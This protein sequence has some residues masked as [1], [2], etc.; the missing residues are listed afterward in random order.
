MLCYCG[1][2][3]TSGQRKFD[4][5]TAGPKPITLERI[6]SVAEAIKMIKT[7]VYIPT[8]S[9]PL[10]GDACLNTFERGLIYY[11]DQEYSSTGA[12]MIFEWSGPVLET[13][14]LPYPVNT[15][16][17]HPG[18]RAA[19]PVGTNQFLRAVGLIKVERSSWEQMFP[20]PN[21]L[22]LPYCKK[23]WLQARAIRVRLELRQL[24][25]SK[26]QIQVGRF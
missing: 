18:W 24:L 11:K 19:I 14:T 4:R 1:C 13:A 21:W 25:A 16:I 22:I 5:M 12:T 6:T 23:R 20:A 10:N 9:D 15:L 17:R 26:P 7:G 8:N 3:L 2:H